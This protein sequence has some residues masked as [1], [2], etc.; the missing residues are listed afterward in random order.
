M[1]LL[2][3]LSKEKWNFINQ[4]EIDCFRGGNS[5]ANDLRMAD[6]QV[7]Q[8]KEDSISFARKSLETEN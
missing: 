5:Y 6:G 2:F 8:L 4:N 3:K 7:Q 1:V